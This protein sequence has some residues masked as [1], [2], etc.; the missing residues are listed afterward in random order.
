MKV[1]RDRSMGKQG[2]LRTRK[3]N[4]LHHIWMCLLPMLLIACSGSL[5][6][7]QL[8]NVNT[9]IAQSET[10][11]EQAHL[12][13]AQYLASDTLQQAENALA[14]AKEAV[15]AKD[16]LGAM[17]LA[18]NALTQA[19]IAEQEAMY[20]SQG[21]GL[22]AIIKRKEAGIVALEANL[23]TTDETLEK[24]RTDV[25]QLDL[26][27]DQLQADMDQKL[28]AAEQA[29]REI[30][31]DYNKARTECGD[32]QSKL[33]TTQ[34]QLLQAQSRGEE[35]ER[36]AHQ[37]RRELADAQ[38]LVE[39]ARKEAA[40]ARTQA[41]AQVQRYS[42]HIEQLDQSNVLKRQEDTLAQKKQE[43]KAYVQQQRRKQ[44]VRTNSTSLT[45]GQIAS[46]RAVISDWALA[47]TAKDIHQHLSKYTQVAT[48]DQTVIR[49][50]N[51][52]QTH[53]NRLQMVDAL[54]QMANAEWQETDSKFDADG[55]SVIAIYRLSRLSRNAVSGGVPALH[56]LWTREV[57]VH[58]VGAEWK[59]FR[60][61]WRI[62][63]AV[64]RYGTAFN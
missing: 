6:K 12:A 46:G 56:D 2:L 18:Y 32:L 44:A 63:E 55:E 25:R 36:Q 37:L 17:H 47:W 41:A 9:V 7:I 31:Q 1:L 35:H 23:K 14:S 26:Q 51:E 40:E 5:G 27:K 13:N 21:N 52:E 24:S 53:L 4:C 8:E 42:K 50:S 19:Q 49:S 30:L 48:L 54:K 15:S 3:K 45:N 33:N 39:I 10:A 29:H 38:S 11:I 43:A 57:W 60:E 20:K 59:I 34:T 28:Q 61:S 64:P 16:G 62:Y 22:N 58:Q